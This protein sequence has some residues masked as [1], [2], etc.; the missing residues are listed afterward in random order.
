[1]PK[2]LHQ[3]ACPCC[4][5]Q[6]EI[7]TRSGQARAVKPA[8]AKGGQD[9]DQM[10]KAQKRDSERLGKVFDDAKGREGQQQDALADLLK[11]AKQDAKKNPD[12]KLRRPW[13]LE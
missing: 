11:Q 10:F 3:F 5:K 1:M 4:G 2:D 9:L 12:E 13:D 8:E 6:I 7:D